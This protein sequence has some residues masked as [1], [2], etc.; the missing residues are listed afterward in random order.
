MTT[1]IDP[2]SDFV[3][4]VKPGLKVDVTHTA[5][6]NADGLLVDGDA[7]VPITRRIRIQ[8]GPKV[9]GC[10]GLLKF[11]AMISNSSGVPVLQYMRDNNSPMISNSSGVPDNSN[12]GHQLPYDF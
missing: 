6:I 11:P 12:L 3:G 4:Q 2:T 8:W 1:E 10:P 7:D 9:R 5:A